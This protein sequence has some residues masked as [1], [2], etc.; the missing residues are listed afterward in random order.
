MFDQKKYNCFTICPKIKEI[1]GLARLSAVTAK[2]TADETG[3]EARTNSGR[4][5]E[6]KINDRT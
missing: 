4:P 5:A 6:K 3:G 2:A 1:T